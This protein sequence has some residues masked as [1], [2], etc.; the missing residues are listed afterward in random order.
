MPR[1]NECNKFVSLNTDIEPE[2]ISSTLNFSDIGTADYDIDIRI[3]N[4]CEE[5]GTELKDAE[6]N[7]SGSFDIECSDYTDEELSG[8][9][10]EVEDL[11]RTERGG[12][13]RY[14]KKFYGFEGTAVL[15]DDDH[16]EL[17]RVSI[18][19]DEQASAMNDL[20]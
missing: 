14:D 17:E 11:V 2:E 3:V 15:Y 8:W 13:N 7:V 16:K 18:A 20:Q 10:L 1:C 12:T 9:V 6:L 4:E 19:E 5:C